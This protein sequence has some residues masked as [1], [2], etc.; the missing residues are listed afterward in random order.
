MELHAVRALEAERLVR[1]RRRAREAHG[2]FGKIERVAVPLQGH[3]VGVEIAEDRIAEAL[4][5]QPD[6]QEADLGLGPRV[7]AR[8][9]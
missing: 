5:R 4:V 8:A 1:V 3:E 6:G 2:A 7:D 9:E